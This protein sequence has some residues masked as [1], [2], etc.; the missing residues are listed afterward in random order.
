MIVY[1]FIFLDSENH[2]M[3]KQITVAVLMGGDSAERE[4]SLQS[5]KAVTSALREKGYRVLCFDPKT[6]LP[7]FI[8]QRDKIDVVFPTL[9]GK[10]GEDG[11]IQGLLEFLRVPFV[12]SGMRGM[13]NSFDK[14]SAKEIYRAAKLPVAKDVIAKIGEDGVENKISKRIGFP[15]FVKPSSEGSSF[16]ASIV[17]KKSEL[18]QALK[19]AWKYGDALVEEYLEGVEISVGV[20]EKLDGGLQALPS[21]EITPR[22]KFFDFRSKYDSKFVEE[23]VP[24]RISKAL[25]KKAQVL[26][27]KAHRALGLKDLSRTDFIIT[28]NKIYLLETNTIPGFTVNSLYPKEALSAGIE[29]SELTEKLIRLNLPHKT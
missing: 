25:E 14:I 24:A 29:F 9:H 17:Q 5:G 23:I 28:K 8:Q 21:I 27:K 18:F 6:D 19:R 16:G 10:G 3:K 1:K 7:K 15:C 4:I 12:G 11:S 22:G 20:L 13:L 26:A 2:K